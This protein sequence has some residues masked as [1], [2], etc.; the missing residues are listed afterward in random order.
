M[1]LADGHCST[2]RKGVKSYPL[3][4]SSAGALRLGMWMATTSIIINH[5]V[6]FNPLDLPQQP[7]VTAGATSSQQ[8][9][10]ESKCNT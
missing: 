4:D 8:T 5:S 10:R 9:H 6:Y 3:Y 1:L 7:Q 2:C